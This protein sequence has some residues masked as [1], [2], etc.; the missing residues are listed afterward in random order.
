[1]GTRSIFGSEREFDEVPIG[2]GFRISAFRLRFT[3]LGL[4]PVGGEAA[5]RPAAIG[6]FPGP[7][8]HLYRIR[9]AHQSLEK[10]SFYEG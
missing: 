4:R 2:A 6:V 7:R 5:R 3:V 1:M 9:P 10:T 8:P